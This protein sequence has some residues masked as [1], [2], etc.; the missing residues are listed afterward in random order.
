METMN[1]D[2]EIGRIVAVD[3]AQVSI[4]LNKDLRALTRTT[5]EGV[6]D[7]GRINS[8]VIIPV[9]AHRLVAI[10]TRVV[11]AEEAEVRADRTLVTLPSARRL[12]KATLIGTIDGRSFTQGVSFF[13]VLDNPVLLPTKNDLDIIFEQ[14]QSEEF[15]IEDPGYCIKIGES[16]LFK[17]R[18]INIDPDAF[19]GKHAAVLGSTG[20]GK[21]CTI[22]SIIQSILNREDIQRTNF[23][24]LDTNGEYRSAFQR[25]KA[26]ETNGEFIWE[27]IERLK[28]LYIPSESNS[29]N[30]LVI[31]YW[32][33]NSDDF[34]RL[35]RA[36]PGVQRPVLLDA[37]TSS[38]L[39]AQP[40]DEWRRLRDDIIHEANS[41]LSYS[42]SRE[43]RD[44]RVVRQLCDQIIGLLE[45]N[46][47]RNA[48]DELNRMYELNE[49][50]LVPAFEK[51]REIAREGIQNEG[52]QYER[53]E[54]IGANKRRSI[55][56]ILQPLLGKISSRIGHDTLSYRRT[57]TADTPVYFDKNNF[58]NI[59]IEEALTRQE[60]TG[61]RARDN[62]ATMLMRIYRLLEDRRFEFLF[63]PVDAQLSNANHSLATFLRDILGLKS[64]P[65]VEQILD[66]TSTIAERD[67]P[68]YDRQRNQASGHNIVVI[69]LSL[70]SN[71]V[72]ENVTALI[73]RLIL[74]FLQRLG[75]FDRKDSRGALPI[76]LILEEAQNYIREQKLGDGESI[77]REVF[78]RIAR[79]GRKYGLGL[80]VSSQRP[81]EL[82]KTVL[83]QCSSF[84]VH[85]LQ[86]PEDLRYFKD[87]VPGVYS[88]LL[89]QLP[90]LAP[91][92]ALILGE[93]VRAPAL[94]QI[95]DANPLPR[96]RDPKFYKHWVSTEDIDIPVE[97]ICMRWGG[98][99]NE[100]PENDKNDSNEQIE[101]EGERSEENNHT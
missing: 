71:E 20:S 34:T 67:L 94:L 10:V 50:D 24:I 74:E 3:T 37:L 30:K 44:A 76:V 18:L 101:N 9:G 88:G 56:G 89:D 61:A 15:D 21:S 92:T 68:F 97:E 38:R 83:S 36:A 4:E 7:V 1:K 62:S 41:I 55:E 52:R 70:L 39:D 27:P 31:P 82:S 43:A 60:I 23:V 14:P 72:L 5:Y 91:Q 59:Y 12:M 17:S 87:I 66:D 73:G 2:F 49:N 84:I 100:N 63:G 77:S 65:D 64:H 22:A 81:S 69:D 80:V 58:R 93:C 75:E 29:P 54:V 26:N 19:F 98:R 33:L 85:R 16:I 42:R 8:Y 51:I 90:A 53:Y 57:I 28:S 6:Q 25:M 13:P 78:E 40:S 99:E 47:S 86:N 46:E 32:F 11:I 48:L 95:R 79:E 45:A 96:S 35:F